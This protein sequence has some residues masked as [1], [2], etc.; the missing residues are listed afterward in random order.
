MEVLTVPSELDFSGPRSNQSLIDIAIHISK[1]EV[2]KL[3]HLNASRQ[4]TSNGKWKSI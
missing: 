1:G 4:I 3:Y 2:D